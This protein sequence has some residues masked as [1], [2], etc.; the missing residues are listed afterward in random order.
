MPKLSS[1]LQTLLDTPADRLRALADRERQAIDQ[2]RFAIIVKH[3]GDSAA[4]KAA[5][6]VL[7]APSGEFATGY[8]TAETIHRLAALD[9]VKSISTLNA[10]A[11]ICRCTAC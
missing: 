2:P 6:L 11:A 3:D 9:G 8:A 7:Q 5:G 1:R 10:R 4:L